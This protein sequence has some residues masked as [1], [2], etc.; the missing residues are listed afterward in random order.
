M[1]AKPTARPALW[2]DSEWLECLSVIPE[3]ADCATFVFAAPSGAQF[4]YDP[5]QF[6]TLDLPVPGGNLQRTYTISS[7]PTRP[8]RISVT[9]K[10]QAGSIGT[11]WMLDHLRPGQ[12]LRVWGPSGRF[13]FAHH[14]APK[15]LLISGGSGI[16]P[17]LSMTASAFDRAAPCDISFVHAARRPE[18]IIFHDG[19]HHWATRMAG[20]KLHLVVEDAQ[21]ARPPWSGYEGR[22]NAEMLALMVPDLITREVFCCGPEPFMRAVRTILAALGH[23]P[24]RYH[25]ESFAAPLPEAAPP[26]RATA[27]AA[28]GQGA[29]TAE[30]AF[31]RSGLLALCSPEETVLAVAKRSGLNIPT[32]CTFGLCG[33]CKTRK[34]EGEV[35]MAHNGG[36]SDDEI[37]EGW[38]LACCSK[39]KGR[40]SIDL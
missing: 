18:D 39:P 1:M 12:K 36:I 29:E 40:V 6:L 24:A 7:P 32:G 31:A 9:V 21:G 26:A 35:D 25:E 34:I 19:L 17:M 38:I 15:Y 27:P 5:G 10:A 14:R 4:T 13:S 16:T 3:T 23:D 22:I 33:T 8:E 2:Q 30:I 11:R 28:M 20:L 37:A